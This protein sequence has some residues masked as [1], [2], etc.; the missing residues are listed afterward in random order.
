[1][2]EQWRLPS[3]QWIADHI[4]FAP[5]MAAMVDMLGADRAAVL[6]QFVAMLE[7]DQGQGE[8]ALSAIAHLGVGIN[9]PTSSEK[10]VMVGNK[11]VAGRETC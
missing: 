2:E 7:R 10:S 5:G 9:P 1:M 8:I 3:A 6:E 11:A 4:A